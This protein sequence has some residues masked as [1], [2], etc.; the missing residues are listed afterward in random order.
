MPIHLALRSVAA[1]LAVLATVASGCSSSPDHAAT[2]TTSS[3]SSGAG[4]ASSSGTTTASTSSGG[5]TMPAHLPTAT[6]TCPA[7]GKLSGTPVAFAGQQAT[8]WSGDPA[9]G[10]GPLLLYYFATGSNSLE[11]ATTIGTAQIAKITSL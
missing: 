1:P 8:V 6:G 4:G 3:N 10:G 9:V 5:G 7:M 2:G 11:P